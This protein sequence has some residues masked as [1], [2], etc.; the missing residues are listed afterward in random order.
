MSPFQQP[1]RT[2]KEIA[3]KPRSAAI[4]LLA[5]VLIASPVFAQAWRAKIDEALRKKVSYDFTVIALADVFRLLSQDAD[6]NII[7]DGPA[8]VDPTAKISFAA[9]D[10]TL[11]SVL[12]W[13]TRIAGLEWV[14]QDEA[15][16]IT[17][18]P[19]LSESARRQIDARNVAVRTESI[20]TWLPAMQRTLSEKVSVSFVQ[21]SPSDCRDSLK[22]LLGVNIIVSPN[23]DPKASV[24]LAVS[25]M[26]A[27]NVLSWV[28]RKAGL[29]FAVLDEA[30]YFAPVDE[31]RIMR[32]TGLDLS[33]QGKAHDLVSFDFN[34]D[35][36]DVAI[37]AL[38]KK[39]GVKIFLRGCPDPAPRV[40]LVGSDMPLSAALQA[41]VSK[42]GLNAVVIP[43]GDTIVISIVAAPPKPVVA[44][45]QPA[46]QPAP[47]A[48]P[49]ETPAATTDE[50]PPGAAAAQ[51]E[52]PPGDKTGP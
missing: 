46:V 41:A 20:K 16:F 32:S 33:S 45:P 25:K 1:Y 6:V 36:L 31:I 10:M 19:R 38:A 47:Q 7:L 44:P 37:D 12:D 4:L 24:T 13:I 2:D 5:L 26:T 27:E 11:G 14:V 15:I 8:T 34:D 50:S 18:Y 9:K 29:D 51:P 30:V 48:P 3:M 52:A 40:S 21:K 49:A 22:I 42:T 28:A 23:I 39:S 35:P 17:K 43:E